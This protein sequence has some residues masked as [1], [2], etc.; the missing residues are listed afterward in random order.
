VPCVLA[1]TNWD[2][3]LIYS[4][5]IWDFYIIMRINQLEISTTKCQHG[6]HIC[7]WNFYVVKSHQIDYRWTPSIHRFEIIWILQ[8]LSL[9]DKLKKGFK[10]WGCF[11]HQM[12][13]PVTSISSCVLNHYNLFYKIQ[14]A[15]A[16]NHDMC[17]HLVLCLWL[18]PFH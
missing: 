15:L 13:V 6:S 10:K 17:C 14:N 4:I 2:L 16:F 1:R 18:L 5:F 11:T 3:V 8:F 9:F 12:A 7:F